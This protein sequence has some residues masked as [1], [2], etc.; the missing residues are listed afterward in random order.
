MTPICKAAS[1][2][3]RTKRT[4]ISRSS[5]WIESI[6][7][8]VRTEQEPNPDSRITLG[9]ELDAL[10]QPCAHLHW[11]L[12]ERDRHTQVVAAKA[13]GEELRRLG[14]GELQMA[15]W[16]AST[17]GEWSPDLVGGHHH[18]GTTR[19]SEDPHAG[20]V[21]SDC[22]THAVHNLYIAGSSVFPTSGFVNPTSTLLALALRLADHLKST[23][24]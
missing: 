10:G 16:L 24:V 22:R 11:D 2:R 9:E 18:M 7:L 14:L 15:P 8:E 21:D 12:T 1:W 3:C 19:M 4:L 6:Y 20:I 13:F 5:S 17:E 23:A